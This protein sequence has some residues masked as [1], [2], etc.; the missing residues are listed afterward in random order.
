MDQKTSSIFS[1]FTPWARRFTDEHERELQETRALYNE[2]RRLHEKSPYA[3]ASL[4]IVDLVNGIYRNLP[5]YGVH[6]DIEGEFKEAIFQVLELDPHVCRFPAWH[7]PL[8]LREGVD[9]RRFLR[10]K[11]HFLSRPEHREYLITALTSMFSGIAASMPMALAPSPF[12]ISLL[13][14]LPRPAE[15]VQNAF[16][17]LSDQRLV[18]AGLFADVF[19]RY[20]FNLAE[21]CG[22]ADINNP[23]SR[24]LKGPIE[25]KL[26][27]SEYERILKGTPLRDLLNAPVPLKFTNEER[28][29]HMH[30][31]GGSGAGKTTLLQNLI[32]NDLKAE[33][34]PS[35]IIVDSQRDMIS[36]LTRLALLKERRVLLISP[37]DIHHPPAIN[38]F[39][40]KRL[41]D[42]DEAQKEQLT[43]GVLETF[44]YLF[45]GLIGAELTPK[46]A[47][48][49]RYVA[50]MMLSLPEVMERNATI[51]D[52]IDF[53]DRPEDYRPVI[54]TLPDIQRSF[55]ERDLLDPKKTTFKETKE[56]VRY[57]LQAILENPTL[58]RL[59]T[60]TETKID[61]F[62]ELNQGTVVLVDT[63]KDFLKDASANFGRIVISLVL[64]AILERS[65]IDEAERH[66]TFLYVDEAE[67]YFD[68]NIDDLLTQVRKYKM[69]CIFA[70]QFLDQAAP[71]LRASLA[72]NTAIKFAGGA[73]VSDARAMAPD[74]RTTADFITSQPG[75]HFAG[76]IRNVTP[77]AVAIPVTNGL[78]E[79]EPQLT[80]AEHEA[81]LALNRRLVSA[82]KSPPSPKQPPEPPAFG[83]PDKG[84]PP[85]PTTTGKPSSPSNP[86]AAAD[87]W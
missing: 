61:L 64:Q 10:A 81:F 83:R 67:E 27:L 22:I 38:I 59:F 87:E 37:R 82:P 24:T 45:A 75:F 63:A 39:D 36:R 74:M 19:R 41:G 49:F 62:A 60:S 3:D 54:E 51:L 5:N 33:P 85:G 44:D 48:F 78:L 52:I 72:A 86:L 21:I 12:V 65:V 4:A 47:V 76:Y 84:S 35:L 13:Y 57:R 34:S 8:S 15:I 6:Q 43:A 1:V 31:L 71:Q 55:F 23:G 56:Q 18:D 53:I 16:A 28:F 17:E 58:A 30:V 77:S 14:T 73:S 68:T 79:A 46:Q 32:L 80:A 20:V 50:R 40:V 2:V 26:P 7:E 70:H 11:K 9:L 69:G 42:Y 25:L 66:P 29:S